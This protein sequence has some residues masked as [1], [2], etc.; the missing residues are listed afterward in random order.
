MCLI[1]WISCAISGM[2]DNETSFW[3]K[4]RQCCFR[5]VIPRIGCRLYTV[6]V[7]FIGI[8]I[9]FPFFP[10]CSDSTQ[11]LDSKWQD[12]KSFHV[13]L[14]QWWGISPQYTAFVSVLDAMCGWRW[15]G[16]IVRCGCVCDCHE[17]WIR[18]TVQTRRCVLWRCRGATSPYITLLGIWSSRKRDPVGSM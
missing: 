14:W 11:V 6:Y 8:H 10:T 2:G 5:P 15:L 1:Q 3:N 17:T 12:I 7:R 4:S 9:W 16:W 13:K 18:T